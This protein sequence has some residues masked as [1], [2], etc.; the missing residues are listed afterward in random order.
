MKKKITLLGMICFL[1]TLVFSIISCEEEEGP[2]IGPLYDLGF[3]NLLSLSNA[4]VAKLYFLKDDDEI[5]NIRSL[6]DMKKYGVADDDLAIKFDDK[7]Y[8]IPYTIYDIRYFGR[9]EN[10]GKE[11]LH[12]KRNYTPIPGTGMAK[13]NDYLYEKLPFEYIGKNEIKIGDQVYTYRLE[14]KE[15]VY[16]DI[17]YYK[18]YGSSTTVKC[19]FY[20]LKIYDYEETPPLYGRVIIK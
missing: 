5:A 15:I 3:Y 13:Y 11:M 17:D 16:T 8:K 4:Q 18:I 2:V 9:E 19:T 10:M 1:I 7:W 12:L 14:K 6:E 20:A